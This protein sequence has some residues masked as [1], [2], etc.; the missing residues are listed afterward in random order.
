M[1]EDRPGFLVTVAGVVL[2]AGIVAALYL[3]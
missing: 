1:I 3:F 2:I